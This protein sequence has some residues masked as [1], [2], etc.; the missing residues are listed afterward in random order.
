MQNKTLVVRIVM[1]AVVTV[2][3]CAECAYASEALAVRIA[4]LFDLVRSPPHLTRARGLDTMPTT[5]CKK[6]IHDR[7]LFY[8]S[9]VFNLMFVVGCAV[10]SMT[11]TRATT[12][13]VLSR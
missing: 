12:M 11:N 1:V 6:E 4:L 7:W 10:R 8:L 3:A 2:D 9:R 13:A 5:M